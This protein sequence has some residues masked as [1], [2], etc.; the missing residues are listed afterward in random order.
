MLDLDSG[1]WTELRHAYG[2]AAEIPG[3]LRQLPT[4]PAHP[5]DY[6]QEPWYSLWSAL[7]HQSDVYPASYAALPHIVAAAGSRLPEDRFE[8]LHLA[9]MIESMRHRPESPALPGDLEPALRD[10]LRRAVPLTLDALR[11]E[12]G[13]ERLRVLLGALAAF[14]G[15]PK[16]GAAIEE[17][18]HEVDCP[19]CG[20][21][22]RAPGYDLFE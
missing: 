1:R 2:A 18:T 13:Q 6:Q 12:P 15:F 7:C 10:A 20:M 3:L 19:H 17:L 11:I 4:A 5:T 22:F 16:L 9:G 21:D 8:Y 14:R